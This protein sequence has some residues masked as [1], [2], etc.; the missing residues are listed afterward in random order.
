[1]PIFEKQFE[2][3]WRNVDPN[4]HLA[5]T[6]YL[7]FAVDTRIAYFTSCGFPPQD[8]QKFGFG[9]VIKTDLVEYFRELLLLDKLTVTMEDGGLAPDGSRFKIVNNF[10][11][12]DGT[13]SA[14]VTSIG[15]WLGFKE[16]KLIAP[17]EIILR[18]MTSLSR[19]EDYEELRSSIKK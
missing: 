19:T 11:K 12:A 16:R 8:F 3:G 6:D 10:Y 13:L 15:G 5:N 2:V 14:K 17:P 7:E 1:V 18:A 9:P 4:G